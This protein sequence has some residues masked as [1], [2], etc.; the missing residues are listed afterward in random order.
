[1]KGSERDAAVEKHWMV[2][3]NEHNKRK[4]ASQGRSAVGA[5]SH[6]GTLQVK[7]VV[8]DNMYRKQARAKNREVFKS[9]NLS[10]ISSRSCL[11]ASQ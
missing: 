8:L 9:L 5:T 6:R 10:K 3:C 7:C 2:I 1:V 4:Q 11:S